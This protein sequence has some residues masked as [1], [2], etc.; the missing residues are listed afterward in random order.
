MVEKTTLQL[1]TELKDT[2]DTLKQKGDTYEDVIRRLLPREKEYSDVT[3][4]MTKEE[5]TIVMN[6]Q[7]W[8]IAAKILEASRIE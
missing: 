6:R 2:L 3:L 5:Y 4:T 7:D 1:S 8:D